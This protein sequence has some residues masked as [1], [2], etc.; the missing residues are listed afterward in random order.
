MTKSA[1]IG[2]ARH[3]DGREAAR[4]AVQNALDQLGNSRP[5]LAVL[6]VA[7]DFTVADVLQAAGNLLGNVPVWGLHTTCPLSAEGEQPRTVG[8]A[9]IAGS[10]YRATINWWANFAQDGHGV[11]T[12]LARAVRSQTGTPQGILLAADG[13]NGDASL[14]C[15]SIDQMNLHVAGGLASGDYRSGRTV[16]IGG[17]HAGSGALSALFL[18]GRL[19]LGLGQAHGWKDTGWLWK[20]TRVR[21]LWVQSL[22]DK[23]PAAAFSEVLGY[24]EKDWFS[25]PLSEYVRLY[26]LGIEMDGPKQLLLRSPLRVEVDG[27]LRMNSRIAE[28]KMAHLMV[29]DPAVCQAALKTAADEAIRSLGSATP[30]LGILLVD[31]AW[32]TLLDGRSRLIYEQLQSVLPGVPWI[33]GYTLGQL[34]WPATGSVSSR[35]VNQHALIALIGETEAQA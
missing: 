19:R 2:F 28:G 12:Q 18:G 6:F 20:V 24:P 27:N 29:G 1:V 34:G 21:D 30:L 26:P 7:Q 23:S 25:P 5:A 9:L 16:C 22:D 13:V 31:E 4:Q 10:G 33:G 14:L 3:W 11:A 32:R 35:L 17:N 8:V 15:E